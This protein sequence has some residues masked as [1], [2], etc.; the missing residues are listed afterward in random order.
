MKNNILFFS[1]SIVVSILLG[2]NCIKSIKD[3][4]IYNSDEAGDV[5]YWFDSETSSVHKMI[6]INEKSRVA[7]II[8]YTNGIKTEVMEIIRSEI[9]DGKIRWVYYVPSTGYTVEMKAVLSNDNE[10]SIE[11]N[12]RDSDGETDSG[13]EVLIRCEENGVELSH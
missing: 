10:I 2:L 1:F 12:N 4:S 13:T 6:T 7:S 8:R 9:V 11:W 3:D 5:T